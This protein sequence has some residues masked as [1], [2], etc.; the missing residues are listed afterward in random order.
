MDIVA[1]QEVPEDITAF[2]HAV[3]STKAGSILCLCWV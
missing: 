2:S 1:N 3:E